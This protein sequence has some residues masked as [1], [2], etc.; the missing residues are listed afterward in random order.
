MYPWLYVC[1]QRLNY[2]LVASGRTLQFRPNYMHLIFSQY[3]VPVSIS[4]QLQLQL[5]LWAYCHIE[6]IKIRKNRCCVH[7]SLSLLLLLDCS[8]HACHAYISHSHRFVHYWIILLYYHNWTTSL[9][10]KDLKK[11]FVIYEQVSV[12]VMHAL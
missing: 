6:L 9:S 3:T 8:L 1:P 4:L 11:E 5:Q 10:V 12:C 7:Y 2:E